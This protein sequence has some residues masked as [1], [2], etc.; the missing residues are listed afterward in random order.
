MPDD[1]TT[2][3]PPSS[4]PTTTAQFA[5]QDY[6]R[7]LPVTGSALDGGVILAA[8]LIWTGAVALLL[9]SYRKLTRR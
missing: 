9:A 8:A 7:P 1:Y 5:Q 4:G 2:Q 6:D 3:P